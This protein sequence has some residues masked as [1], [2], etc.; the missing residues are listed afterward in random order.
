MNV[1]EYLIKKAAAKT[2]ALDNHPVLKGKQKSALPDKIQALI[3]KKKME[4]QAGAETQL[5]ANIL[6]A[7]S[8]AS[9]SEKAMARGLM[10]EMKK[11]YKTRT[12]KPTVVG[13]HGDL[14]PK[15]TPRRVYGEIINEGRRAMQGKPPSRLG[16]EMRL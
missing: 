7:G 12:R 13:Y 6:R 5:I 2:K 14:T 15:E 9:A 11:G 16:R 3:I 1:R 4:K 10:R 8:G